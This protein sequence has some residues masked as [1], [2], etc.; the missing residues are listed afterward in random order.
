MGKMS[1]SSV[2][3][4]LS[5][6]EL[7]DSVL[8]DPSTRYRLRSR[9]IEDG[10]VDPADALHDAELL[11]ELATARIKDANEELN[12]LIANQFSASQ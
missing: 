1:N 10:G 7:Y 4:K 5:Y 12:N 2:D 8:K 9:M 3:T 6:T 11:F